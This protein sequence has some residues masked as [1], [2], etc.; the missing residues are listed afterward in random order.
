MSIF[1]IF[2]VCLTVVYIIYYTV[3]ICSD[4]YRKPKDH[5]STSVE[6]FE[7]P[8]QPE[9]TSKAVEETDNE[10]AESL[11]QIRP[12]MNGELMS[13]TIE[14]ALKEGRPPLQIEKK[15]TPAPESETQTE[16]K[17]NEDAATE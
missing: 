13:I 8:D 12:E 7:V 17:G 2:C 6:T 5:S 15:V 14:S 1:W 11:E 9:E 4:L 16:Q 10:A 3:L